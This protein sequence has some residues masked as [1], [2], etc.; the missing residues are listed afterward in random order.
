MSS[1]YAVAIAATCY[2]T[3]HNHAYTFGQAI[4]QFFLGDSR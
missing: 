3:L 2:T 4:A 1:V